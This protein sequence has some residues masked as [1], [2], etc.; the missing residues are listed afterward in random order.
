[1]WKKITLKEIVARIDADIS[2]MLLNKKPVLR[3]SVLHILATAFGGAVFLYLRCLDYIADQLFVSSCDAEFLKL[4]GLRYGMAQLSS[5]KA[6][7]V[8]CLEIFGD[9]GAR[10]SGDLRFVRDDGVQYE[11]VGPESYLSTP[12]SVLIDIRAIEP[13]AIG[14]MY[15]TY[16]GKLSYLQPVDKFTSDVNLVDNVSGGADDEDIE[17]FR[18]R[19]KLREK[20]PPMGGADGDYIEMA[21]KEIS[22]GAAWEYKNRNGINSVDVVIKSNDPKLP[23]PGIPA[24]QRIQDLLDKDKPLTTT[25]IARPVSLKPV[26]WKIKMNP[27][28]SSMQDLVRSQLSSLFFETGAPESVM[29]V[30]EGEREIQSIP[31]MVAAQIIGVDVA[32]G[33]NEIPRV[34]SLTFENY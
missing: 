4:R 22:V 6:S 27:N 31:G 30:T 14:N 29:T 7:G 18:S 2:V 9:T 23:S 24:L 11:Y 21:M 20:K 3:T 34:G 32:T 25:C 5:S 26:N 33:W 28:D 19:V 1:M 15:T 10:L 17:R 16:R 8:A 13:G 12:G